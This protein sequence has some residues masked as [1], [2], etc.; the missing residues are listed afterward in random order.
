MWANFIGAFGGYQKHGDLGPT[1]LNWICPQIG[2]GKRF[3]TH[4]QQ[5][6]R[7]LQRNP[8]VQPVTLTLFLPPTRETRKPACLRNQGEVSGYLGYGWE[9]RGSVDHSRKSNARHTAVLKEITGGSVDHSYYPHPFRHRC[10]CT[11]KGCRG[12]GS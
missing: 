7:L 9:T 8:V 2:M 6:G 12:N 4:I 10:P 11:Y 3:Q 1:I 5:P